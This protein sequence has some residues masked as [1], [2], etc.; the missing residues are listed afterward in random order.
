MSD[1][2]R[3]DPPVNLQDLTSKLQNV[4]LEAAGDSGFSSEGRE[5][6]VKTGRSGSSRR[7]RWQAIQDRMMRRAKMLGVPYEVLLKVRSFWMCRSVS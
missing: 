6:P 4:S 1:D 2:C 5:D 7:R 3:G